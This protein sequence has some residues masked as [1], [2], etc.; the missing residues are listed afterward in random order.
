[1]IY[2]LCLWPSLCLS[3]SSYFSVSPPLV[4]LRSPALPSIHSSILMY[5]AE[6]IDATQTRNTQV[7]NDR[8]TLRSRNCFCSVLMSVRDGQMLGMSGSV[9]VRL[10]C[11]VSHLPSAV[12]RLS[13]RL[14]GCHVERSVTALFSNRFPTCIQRGRICL[15]WFICSSI[16]SHM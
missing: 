9:S 2:D 10:K 5:N 11:L 8:Q 14:A 3:L 16:Q 4:I 13:Y 7:Q 1:M 12:C 6:L 15:V